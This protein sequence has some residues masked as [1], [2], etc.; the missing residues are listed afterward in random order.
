MTKQPVDPLTD[1]RIFLKAVWRTHGL[2][3]PTLAQ[4]DIAYWLQHGPPERVVMAERG[5]GKTWITVAFVLWAL[6]MN[7]NERVLLI[8]Q[9]AVHARKS[10]KLARQWIDAIPFLSHMKPRPQHK[11]RDGVDQFDIGPASHDRMASVTALGITGQIVGNRGSLI[12]PDDIETDETVLT[13]NSREQLKQRILEF[14]NVRVPG[15]SVV[16]LGTPHHEDSIYNEFERIGYAI[17]HWPALYPKP[18]EATAEL[19]PTL[20][21]QM[22]KNPDLVGTSVS[23]GR[24]S[25]VYYADRLVKVGKANFAQQYMLR[26]DLSDAERCPL[27]L[28]DLIV[29]PVDASYAPIAISW[30]QS[31]HNGSTRIEDIPN[32]GLPGD[33]CY[34][35]IFIHHERERYAGTKMVIDPAGGEGKTQGNRRKQ[36]HDE[37]A[38][39]I[40]GQLNGY[41][42]LKHVG[43]YRG[44][45][46]ESNLRKIV[47]A[48]RDY[49]VN[50]IY[51]EK[52]FGGDM[53]GQLLKPALS[54]AF[55]KPGDPRNANGWA[56]R[57]ESY[58]R[59]KWDGAKH[60]RII[61]NLDPILLQHRLIVD[62]AVV[63]DEAFAYQL[64]H[65]TSRKGCIPHDDR[66]EA[67]AECVG[68]F[69]DVMD[70]DPELQAQRVLDDRESDTDADWDRRIKDDVAEPYITWAKT[71]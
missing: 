66:V 11:Q 18:H 16:V 9:S 62:P 29:Y 65:I 55:L 31:D 68:F 3:D 64:T 21:K 61:G 44:G 69:M 17:R 20:V 26:N 52:N 2:P 12:I 10:L 47:K 25:D 28:K 8:S 56:A 22:E 32:F 37:T 36:R 45:H 43:G 58:S 6:Y 38:W 49:A 67:V 42:F 48:A 33:G 51:I 19:S 27:K 4:Q 14:E 7:H 70:Q 41:L 60:D 1:F 39:A 50:D 5:E 53:L 57:V 34:A 23:P 15:S 30:G 63:R 40:V 59:T 35:P 71:W 46:D 24:F 13:V 54:R